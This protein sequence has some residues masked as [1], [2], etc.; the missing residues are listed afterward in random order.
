MTARYTVVFAKAAEKE[1][2]AIVERNRDLG[3][4]LSKAIARLA[5]DPRRGEFLRGPWKGY[6]KY[7]VGDY[8]I[9]YRIEHQRLIIYIVTVGHRGEAYRVL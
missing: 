3:E 2:D 8:R 4:R 9:I 5:E 7:R 1:F 6:W